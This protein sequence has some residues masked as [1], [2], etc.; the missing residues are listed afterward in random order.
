MNLHEF[1]ASLRD[2]SLF[3]RGPEDMPYSPRLLVA[4]LVACGALQVAFNLHDGVKPALITGAVVG[5]LAMVWLV[6]LLLR[7]ASK[8]ERFVQT[9]SA[10]AAVYLLFGL[11]KNLLTL[12]LPVKAW[13]QQMM[14]DPAHLPEVTGHQAPVMLA[15]AVLVIWQFCAWVGVLRRAL[16]IPVAGGVLVFLLLTFV[17][18]IVAALIAGVIGVA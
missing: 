11:A 6:F 5:G 12:L 15:I 9:A 1:L 2:I 17:N 3:R 16:E 18:L 4:L 10:L 7:G 8:S 13:Q 14:A